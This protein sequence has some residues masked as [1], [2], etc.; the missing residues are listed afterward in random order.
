MTDLSPL[1]PKRPRVALLVDGDN[2]SHTHAGVLITKSAKYGTLNV[3]RVYGNMATHPGWDAAP[4]FRSVHSGAGKNAAD[5]LLAVEAMSL[6]LTGQAD[7]LVIASSDRDFSHLALHLTERDHQVIGMGENKAPQHF[8]KSCSVFHE[9]GPVPPPAPPPPKPLPELSKLDTAI[10][11]IIAKKKGPVT[12]SVLA[13]E[14][15]SKAFKLKD[16][17]SASWSKY[18]NRKPDLFKCSGTGPQLAADAASAMP[19][20]T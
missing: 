5:L 2:L 14:L 15:A 8:R 6:I 19:T 20:S 9:I 7:V 4:G 3:K 11:D 18:L 16:S 10:L 13:K 1:C 12:M 17:G